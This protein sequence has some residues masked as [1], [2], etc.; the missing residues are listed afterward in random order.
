MNLEQVK[1]FALAVG[2][3]V[4]SASGEWAQC[5]CPLAPFLHDSGRDSHPS[6][7][8]SYGTNIESLFNCF[9]CDSG[10]LH[11]LVT[12]LMELGA[13][14][15]R[16]NLKAA[17]D[18]WVA[19]ESADIV[20]NFTPENFKEAVEDDVVWPES[21]LDGFLLAHKVPMA[22]R[23][24]DA[25]NVSSELA[26]DLD[27]RWDLPRRAICFPIR[28]WAGGLVGI[29]GRYIDPGDGPS[30]HMYGYKGQRNNLPWYGEATVDLDK[31]VVMVESVFDY[32]STRRVYKNILA[33]LSVGISK[34]KVRRVHDAL[35]IVTLFDNG[36]G[37][38][39]ARDR[40]SK[41]LPKS[42]LIHLY[43][44][45]GTGDP[46]DMTVKQLTKV[47]SPYMVLDTLKKE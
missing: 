33:P 5:R 14:P 11:K 44:P 8:I 16:Y 22:M 15:P 2:T 37:G 17:M 19:E 45:N 27:I 30:Y 47:L 7:A 18:M 12:T 40:V 43:P 13:K 35:E 32:T 39:K 34:G 31:T 1:Q 28:N 6:C 10:D 41:Y 20:L 4:E 9:T 42:Q 3:R 24:L 36:Q 21:F 26:H 46:G 29:R 25:R 23:Y 38:D